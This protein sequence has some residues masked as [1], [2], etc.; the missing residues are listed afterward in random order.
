MS[1]ATY[2]R[3]RAFYAPY[4]QKLL[5]LMENENRVEWSTIIRAWTATDVVEGGQDEKAANDA[6]AEA[7]RIAVPP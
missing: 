7:Q 6:S 5:D 1:C 3:L 4:N 2:D